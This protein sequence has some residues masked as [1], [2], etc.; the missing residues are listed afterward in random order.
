M[1]VLVSWFSTYTS[2]LSSSLLRCE[3]RPGPEFLTRSYTFHTSRNFQALQHYYTDSSCE[4]P[5]YSLIIRGKL[6]LRQ[7]SWITRGGAEAEHHLSKVGIV[8]HSLEA[9]QRLVSRLPSTCVGLTMARVLPGKLFELYNTRMGRG[10]LAAMGFSMMEMGLIRVETQHHNHGGKV[11][12]LFF[13][14]IH[15]EWARRTQYRPTGYQQPLQNAMVRL[16]TLLE[17]P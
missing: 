12:E 15:T 16:H 6:R 10:C 3:V 4:D 5:G 11:Q 9:K 7:A 13:G 1:P 17:Q 14:D 8:V 2:L